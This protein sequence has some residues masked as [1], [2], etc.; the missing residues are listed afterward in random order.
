MEFTIGDGRARVD[1][2]TFSGS[3]VINSSG[4]TTRR[5]DE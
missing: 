5:E 2:Q 3:I 1:A 4:S